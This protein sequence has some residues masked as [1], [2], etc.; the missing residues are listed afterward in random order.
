[1]RGN[2]QVRRFLG[3]CIL[4]LLL[5][6]PVEAGSG[7]CR[8]CR[9]KPLPPGP[10]VK[11]VI[12]LTPAQAE[13]LQNYRPPPLSYQSPLIP[14]EARSLIYNEAWSDVPT[15]IRPVRPVPVET[16]PPPKP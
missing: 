8:S 6:W 15:L 1:M 5:T 10:P 3:I 2:L 13:S 4:G 16:L 7:R 9:S 11:V 12:G 14:P